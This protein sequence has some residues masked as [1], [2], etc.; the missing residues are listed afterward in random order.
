MSWLG[1]SDSF[2]Y[3]RYRSTDIINIFYFHSAGIDFSRQ[4]LTSITV[5]PRAVRV[6]P[7]RRL[8]ASFYI[9][10]NRPNFPTT[11]GFRMN[12]PMNTWQFSL[13]FH[14]HKIIFIHYKS[15][16]ATAN[17][18]FEWVKM[19]MVNSGFKG[20]IITLLSTWVL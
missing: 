15:R 2:E 3:L 19:T 10:E 13:L 8:K 16:I 1:L 12:I 17:G 7:S 5:G 4:N 11:D 14:P 9:P 6:K 20:L 18:G